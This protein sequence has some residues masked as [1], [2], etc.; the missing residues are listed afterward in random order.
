MQRRK[1]QNYTHTA[2]F[3]NILRNNDYPTS[4]TWHLNNKKSWKLHRPFNTCVLK[5]PHFR[6]IMTKEIHRAFYKERLDIQLAHSRPLL[7]QYLTK[8]NH[9]TITTC[10][11]AN[12]PIRDPNI[13]QK[14][15]TIYHLICL[16]CHNFYIGSSIRLL[17]I[18]IKEHLNTRTSSVH[19]HLIKCNSNDDYFSIKIEAIVRNVG[20]LRIKEALLIVKLHPPINSRLEL[21]TEYIVN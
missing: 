8:K 16:K 2:Q 13:C 14:T 10:T 5:L 7:C 20:H 4:I 15:Y 3:I 17:H 1:K 19:K 11:V 9:N 6:E 18:R 21:N 12:C